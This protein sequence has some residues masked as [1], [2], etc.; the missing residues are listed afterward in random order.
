VADAAGRADLRVITWEHGQVD[1]AV[2][3]RRTE[4]FTSLVR[5]GRHRVVGGLVV[6]PRA[7]ETIAELTLA[8]QRGLRARDLAGV[9]HAYPT[10]SGGLWDASVE[11]VRQGLEAPVVRWALVRAV[12]ARRWWLAA[13]SRR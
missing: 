4:G 2:A 10:W 11:D 7:G 3:E 1:R 9:T 8:V 12:Q 5:D 6:G 13:R